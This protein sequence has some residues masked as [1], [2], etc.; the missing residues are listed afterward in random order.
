VV[1]QYL[2][3]VIQADTDK[4]DCGYGRWSYATADVGRQT[5]MRERHAYSLQPDNGSTSSKNDDEDGASGPLPGRT[6]H[7]AHSRE[8]RRVIFVTQKGRR[9]GNGPI[10]PRYRRP[11]KLSVQTQ[12]ASAA[13]KAV[14]ARNGLSRLKATGGSGYV[15]SFTGSFVLLWFHDCST[16][17]AVTSFDGPFDLCVNYESPEVGITYLG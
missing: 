11:R 9:A 1:V 4:R 3:A 14:R 13:D 2:N 7:S 10:S 17:A 15:T 16:I 8:R 12:P 5:L 6:V